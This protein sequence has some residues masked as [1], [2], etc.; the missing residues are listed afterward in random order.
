MNNMWF[1]DVKESA[2]AAATVQEYLFSL[3]GPGASLTLKQVPQAIDYFGKGEVMRGWEQ[4]APAFARGTLTAIRYEEEGALTSTGSSIKEAEE[5][6]QGQLLAQS[7]GFATE[8]LVAQRETIFKLQGEILKVKKER[9][10]L[11]D[12]LDLE[13]NKGDDEDVERV[14][15]KIQKF[16]S[17]NPFAMIEYEN[18]EQ[19][20]DKQAKRRMQADRGMPIDERYFPQVAPVLEA[21]GKKLE[22]ES[23]LNNP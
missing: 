16:N 19:S 17:R 10:K 18:I 14:L 5:F 20:M 1:P 6:T 7:M 12:R 9:A 15:E 22:R 2:T 13:I 21:P 3:L 11:L 8:G 4:L 23:A